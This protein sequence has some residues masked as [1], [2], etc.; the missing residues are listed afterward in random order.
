MFNL[1][2]IQDMVKIILTSNADTRDDDMKLYLCVCNYCLPNVNM[3]PFER[4][5]KEYRSLGI[6]CFESVR[7]TRQKLQADYPELLG[8]RRIKKLR[9][10][11]EKIYRQYAKS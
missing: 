7:R 3:L 5:M 2:T 4:V 11:Q 8:S 10:T 1:K 6:P 9:A